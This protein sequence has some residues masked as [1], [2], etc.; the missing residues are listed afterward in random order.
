MRK[1]NTRI[2]MCGPKAMID[3]NR[4]MFGKIS[5]DLMVDRKVSYDLPGE[6][7]LY[8]LQLQ[9]FKFASIECITECRRE[10]FTLTPSYS[11]FELA[12]NFKFDNW[13]IQPEERCAF[14]C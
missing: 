12:P 8:S 1:E 7:S 9:I 6:V 10:A 2:P 3:L 14:D 5:D 4:R 13:S 11:D